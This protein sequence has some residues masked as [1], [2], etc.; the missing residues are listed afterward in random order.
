VIRNSKAAARKKNIKKNL[1]KKISSPTVEP[2]H[3]Y[4]QHGTIAAGNTNE[5]T[6]L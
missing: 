4:Q 3:V 1:K 2:S 6:F 5:M